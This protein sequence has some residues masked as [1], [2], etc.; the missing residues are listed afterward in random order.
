MG[1]IFLAPRLN[2]KERFNPGETPVKQQQ[3][4]FHEAGNCNNGFTGQAGQADFADFAVFGCAV[5]TGL[6]IPEN[7]K[8]MYRLPYPASSHFL[9]L[10]KD[11]KFVMITR[12]KFSITHICFCNS[13]SIRQRY[14]IFCFQ[15]TGLIKH[16]ISQGVDNCHW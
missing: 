10:Y 14:S 5:G 2:K 11:V 3:Q 12:Y 8:V 9:F 4:R 13:N 6:A 1:L 15:F 16:S 7:G